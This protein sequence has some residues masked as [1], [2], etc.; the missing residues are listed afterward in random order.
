MVFPK[1][2]VLS[3]F[4]LSVTPRHP[5]FFFCSRNIK[6]VLTPEFFFPQFFPKTFFLVFLRTRIYIFFCN[7]GNFITIFSNLYF[8]T[9]SYSAVGLNTDLQVLNLALCV[10]I[11]IGSMDMISR[12]C[13]K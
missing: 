11:N 6:L 13:S 9:F 1:I 12:Q 4:R 2:A 8:S 7:Y 3:V 10:G 5:G